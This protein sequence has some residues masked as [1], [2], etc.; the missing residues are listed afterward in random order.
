[1]LLFQGTSSSETLNVLTK[2]ESSLPVVNQMFKEK[3]DQRY[4]VKCYKKCKKSGNE[5][6]LT[7]ELLD[8]ET[9]NI[10]SFEITQAILMK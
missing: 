2:I 8:G 6:S 1:M 3:K 7:I 5:G 10:E 4:H 9:R